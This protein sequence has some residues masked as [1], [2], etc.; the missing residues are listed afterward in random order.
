[1]PI[2][3]PPEEDTFLAVFQIPRSLMP[4]P[5]P[6]VSA[7]VVEL[8]SLKPQNHCFEVVFWEPSST[9]QA[10]GMALDDLGV[11]EAAGFNRDRA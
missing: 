7:S 1:M 5:E 3:S 4:A 9:V 2:H 6:M 8:K 11:F 10:Y